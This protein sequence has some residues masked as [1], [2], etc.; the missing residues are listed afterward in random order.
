MRLI[1]AAVG[2]TV[3]A[4]L[5]VTVVPYVRVG[6]AYPHL[7]LVLGV[8]WVIAAGFESGLAWAFTGGLILDVLADRP[9]GSTA[10]ALLLSIGGAAVLARLLSRLRP[11]APIPLVFLF[12]LVNSTL[13][14]VFY[15]ALRT[16]IPVANPIETLLPG[17]I[18]DTVLAAV[19][20]PLVIS[21]YDRAAEQERPDW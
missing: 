19:I 12:S 17:A 3:A 1:V 18:Y 7:V 15:G 5:E 6:D 4:L 9:I 2:A 13:V 14:L 8:V 11:L 10:F 20:G 16:P 21:I